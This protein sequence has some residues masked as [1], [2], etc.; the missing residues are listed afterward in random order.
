M[1]WHPI[2]SA[3]DNPKESGDYIVWM[4]DRNNQGYQEIN[5]YDA[6]ENEWYDQEG[7]EA[8]PPIA[9]AHLL[10]PYRPEGE[11]SN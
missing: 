5:N 10:A 8:D 6:Y 7:W 4:L 1:E 2:R 9:W 11:E 3:E